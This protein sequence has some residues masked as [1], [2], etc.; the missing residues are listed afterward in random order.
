L[1]TGSLLATGI[2]PAHAA[3]ATP[4]FLSFE[5][6]DPLKSDSVTAKFGGPGVAIAASA[7][8]TGD[9]MIFTKT[10]DPWSGTNIILPSSTTKRFADAANTIITLD[11]FSND[12]GVSPVQLRL[13]GPNGGQV[14]KVVDAQPGKSTLSFDMSTGQGWNAAIEYNALIIYPNFSADDSGYTGAGPVA[15][16]GQV[17]EID[18]ISI[19][20]GTAANI[21]VPEAPSRAETSTLLTFETSDT[22]GA[23]AVGES[24]PTKP[25]GTFSGAVTVIADAPAGGNGGKVLEIT[26]AG[27]AWSG[28]NLVTAP[29]GVKFGPIVTMNYY[30]PE[31][32][33]TPVQ[34]QLLVGTSQPVSQA[35][36]AAPG[37]QTLTF[38]FTATFNASKEYT[39][40]V[41]FPNFRNAGD[42]PGY[43]GAPAAPVAGKKFAI[44]NVG[45]NGATT[46]AIPVPSGAASTLLTFET[47]DTLGAKAVGESNDN[48]PD[49]SFSGAVTVIVDAPAGGNGGKVLEITKAGDAWSGVNLVT[50]P[51]GVKFGD[52]TK[53]TV[54][55]NY[56]SPETVNTPVQLQLIGVGSTISQAVQA[57]PGWQTLTFDFTAT[58]D[59]TKEYTKAVIFPN[60]V[61]AQ[62][63]PGYTGAPAAPV[64]GK[65]F[66]IDNVG[67]NG[68]TTPAIPVPRVATSTL[69][70]FETS[71]TL[72]AKAVGESS[73]SKPDGSFSG[74]VTVIANAPAG[75]NG[76]KVLEIT[77]AGDAWSGV[78]LV[79]APEGVKFGSV[80]T[81]NYYSPETVNTPVQLQL[82]VGTSTPVSQAVQAVPGWQ[83]L[84]FDFT[85]TFDATKEYTKAVIFPNFVNA[86]D[87]PGYTGAAAAPVAG[88]KF[89]I[90]NVGFNGATT[91]AIP[92]PVV[93]VK[94]SVRTA[95][96]VAGSST[97]V[98]KT[99]TAGKGLW[100]GSSTI[101]YTY[102]W[103]RCSLSSTK[104]STSA[105]T[106]SKCAT[107]SGATKST[108][109]LAKSDIGKYI[110]V[111]VAAKNTAGTAYSMSKTTSKKVVK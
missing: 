19:A 93:K 97:K 80:V 11:Y 7:N 75:G 88:K 111:L 50:A 30:S 56:Y 24:S 86:G 94:P 26:K 64:A 110:R 92:V 65:K 22:L 55:M 38:D 15:N 73:N 2:S 18:N 98:A 70:T 29:D 57:V 74:A 12:A 68:A 17:Y 67:F 31:T 83:R 91:P 13:E 8:L 81:M 33:N 20:G 9:A 23:N 48:K 61:N 45:F 63:V 77:K 104:T 103:Y 72:G 90:D 58:F 21:Y 100:S 4:L 54:T 102:K 49:G 40:A 101:T 47:S 41:I 3:D 16:S 32:V 69:L 5:A 76:G 28:V 51:E 46:P 14:T 42:V 39:K 87:V 84:T 85:A 43:T 79:T 10:G 53:K 109:K 107:I 34:L 25:D 108:Y 99:L 106:P 82:L 89:A 62:D 44:D 35:V 95:A 60:F 78:N 96:S 105:S 27:D 1:A 6:N 37:W 36:E 66:A 52:A 71:D 59:E